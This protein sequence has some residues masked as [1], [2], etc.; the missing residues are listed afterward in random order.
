[1]NTRDILSKVKRIEITTRKNVKDFLSGAYHSA[2]KGSGLEFSEVREYAYGDDVKAIDWNVTARE[3]KPYIKHY[4]EERELTVM[5]L[6]DVSASG[7]FGTKEKNKRETAVEIAASIAFSA[8]RNRDKVGAVFFSDRIEQ[9]IPPGKSKGHLLRIV[10]DLLFLKPLSHRTDIAKALH[11]L[12]QTQKKRVIAFLLSDMIS[13]DFFR[14]A[15]VSGRRHDLVAFRL[16]DPFDIAVRDIGLVRFYDPETGQ[17][18]LLDTSSAGV[19]R[20]YAAHAMEHDRVLRKQMTAAGID[21]IDVD[22]GSD[23]MIAMRR[24]F[25]RRKKQ[26]G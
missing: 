13:T 5:I 10:R 11:Y 1:M 8:N 18:H 16:T 15:R 23:C 9:Y 17:G 7:L 4:I 26:N 22:T 12:N 3:N 25:E 21:M 6:F 20:A 19:R 2:F 14:E 24:F